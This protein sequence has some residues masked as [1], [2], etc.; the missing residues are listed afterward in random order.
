LSTK[1]FVAVVLISVVL[2][3]SVA[4]G[5]FNFFSDIDVLII[6]RE[7]PQGRILRVREFEKVDEQLIPLLDELRR[8]AGIQTEISPI[9]KSP[10]EAQKGSPLFLDMVEDGIILFD[11]DNFFSNILD[12][13]RDRLKALGA[14][15][16]WRG[17]TW[18]WVLKPDFKPGEV[19][20]I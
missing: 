20:E 5:T 14:K 13:L 6:A 4:R 17:E 7:L 3:G 18:H 19:F 16:V 12:R 11:R 8:K 15:R 2:F 1:K 10:E 9:L